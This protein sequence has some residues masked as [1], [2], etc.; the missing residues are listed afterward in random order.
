MTIIHHSC[1]FEENLLRD[2]RE[3]LWWKRNAKQTRTKFSCLGEL[4]DMALLA[5]KHYM[6][7]NFKLL[8]TYPENL[9]I[10]SLIVCTKLVVKTYEIG[11][12]SY[13]EVMISE[14][15]N[16]SRIMI[17]VNHLWK[18]GQTRPHIFKKSRT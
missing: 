16:S 2:L 12:K 7:H 8:P 4:Q 9:I 15:Q 14:L 17:T 5:P 18:D 3:I 10:I 11:R 13:P 6:V 1:K